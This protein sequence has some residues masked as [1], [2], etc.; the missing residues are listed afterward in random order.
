MRGGDQLH[1]YSLWRSATMVDQ[2]VVRIDD[3]QQLIED[4][5]GGGFPVL[6]N[7]LHDLI[8]KILGREGLR[9]VVQLDDVGVDSAGG[10]LIVVEE[11]FMHFLAGAHAG[12]GDVDVTVGPQAAQADHHA[13]RV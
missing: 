11:F 4:R 6:G 5:C 8:I 3:V 1:S 12:K 7:E 9:L 13:V 10:V 2:G